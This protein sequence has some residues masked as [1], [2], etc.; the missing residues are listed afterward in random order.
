MTVLSQTTKLGP[1]AHEMN[2]FHHRCWGLG[3]AKSQSSYSGG[4]L[5]SWMS[6]KGFVKQFEER[7]M[8]RTGIALVQS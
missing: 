2:N 7:A 6:H 1:V 8:K 5:L 4:D 3:S